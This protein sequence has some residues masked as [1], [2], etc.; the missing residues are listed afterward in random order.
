[1][2]RTLT[3]IVLVSALFLAPALAQPAAAQVYGGF[4]VGGWF[5]IGGV[6]FSQVYGAP[7]ATARPGYYYRTPAG[8]G[9]LGTP[10]RESFRQGGYIYYDPSCQA[11][12][13]YFDLHHQRH[14]LLFEGY[15]PP[16]VWRGQFY[17]DRYNGSGN[18]DR[19]R[20]RGD[21]DYGRSW[22]RSDRK[23]YYER[24]GW[25]HRELNRGRGRPRPRG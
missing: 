14:G 1:M 18:Y 22:S 6:S 8:Y 19:N 17:G 24:Y 4:S 16:P 25:S 2:R 13:R 3:S 9:Y 10:C 7:T 23:R 11:V 20:R 15:A 5:R 21:R 12:T